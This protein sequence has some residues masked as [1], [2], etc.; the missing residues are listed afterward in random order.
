MHAVAGA[1]DVKAKGHVL[2]Q[3]LAVLVHFPVASQ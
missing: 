1:T 3:L 2:C